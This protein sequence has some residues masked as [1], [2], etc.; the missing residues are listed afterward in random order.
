LPILSKTAQLPLDAPKLFLPDRIP[1]VASHELAKIEAAMFPETSG[2]DHVKER[3]V[4]PRQAFDVDTLLHLHQ[5]SVHAAQESHWIRLTTIMACLITIVLLLFFSFRSYFRIL[6]LRCWHIKADPFPVA[7]PRVTPSRRR[8]RARRNWDSKPGPPRTSQVHHLC[9]TVRL[10]L[11]V[12]MKSALPGYTLADSSGHCI[13]QL[14]YKRLTRLHSIHA[15]TFVIQ[16]LN[17]SADRVVACIYMLILFVCSL[18]LRTLFV[19]HSKF[20]GVNGI[21]LVRKL[22][23]IF[24]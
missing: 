21:L 12:G 8:T 13:L 4:T 7:A 10:M 19:P 2:L 22:Y 14:D 18:V 1:A 15:L 23:L 5:K 16:K 24:V 9:S 6:F 17:N 20:I 11:N 3:L